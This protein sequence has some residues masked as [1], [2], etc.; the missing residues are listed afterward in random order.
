MQVLMN[1]CR[2]S[3]IVTR[4]HKLEHIPFLPSLHC[5]DNWAYGIVQHC[6]F[7]TTTNTSMFK[8]GVLRN[9]KYPVLY[10]YRLNILQ[11]SECTTKYS[12]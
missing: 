2:I 4:L 3:G 6:I 5:I 9:L 12:M 7:N 11:L 1:D 8:S 10:Q